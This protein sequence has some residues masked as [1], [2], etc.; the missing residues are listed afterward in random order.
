MIE[1]GKKQSLYFE[2]K[3]SD[4]EWANC[5]NCKF[6]YSG[7]FYPNP[8]YEPMKNQMTITATKTL[9]DTSLAGR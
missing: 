3:V 1:A 8:E 4:E 5:K 9:K 7:I 6:M 2:T